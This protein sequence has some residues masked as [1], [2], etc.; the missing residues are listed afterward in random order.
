M[1]EITLRDLEIFYD[2]D[3]L[4][5][6]SGDEPQKSVT[7]DPATVKPLVD[8]VQALAPPEEKEAKSEEEN[9]RESFR[10]P[11]IDESG[12][13]VTLISG[14]N[15]CVSKPT[16]ISMTGVFVEVPKDRSIALDIDDELRARLSMNKSEIE[17][18]AVVRRIEPNGFGLFFPETFK[19]EHV[20]PPPIIRRIV[21]DLQRQW[22]QHRKE[23]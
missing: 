16:N 17:L 2:G 3:T 21:M 10:V 23:L 6:S 5:I 15:R 11:I 19:G 12:L 4:K 8:F 9:R 1:A 18:D 13:S 22:M 20:D 14:K 7:L